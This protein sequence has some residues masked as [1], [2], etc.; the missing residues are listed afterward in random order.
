MPLIHVAIG[1]IIDRNDRVLIAKRSA[2]QHQGNK[3]E[4]PGGKIERD[5]TATEALSR[6]LNE[7][8]DITVGSAIY[9]FDITHEYPNSKTIKLSVYEVKNWSGIAVGREDQPLKWVEKHELQD[10]D[11]PAANTEIIKKLFINN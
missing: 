8:L 3:W 2:D 6:E 5:E 4:F 7:E 10:Y 1:V 9:L 11:F